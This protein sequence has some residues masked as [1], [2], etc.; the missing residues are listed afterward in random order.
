MDV[1]VLV[2][3]LC[4]DYGP[5][6]AVHDLSFTVEAGEIFALVGP[7][8]AGKSTTL[9][10]LEGYRRPTGGRVSVLGM[11]PMSGGRDLRERIGIVLQEAG[12][13]EEFSVRELVELYIGFYPRRHEVDEL[14]DLV[15]LAEKRGSRV[16]TLSGGQRRRLDLALGLA[17][18]PDLIFLDEPT[19]GFDPSAR[20]RAWDLVNALRGLGKTV[21]LTT[22]YMDEA[23]HLADRVAVINSGRLV[24]LGSPEQLRS[25][26][27]RDTVISCRLPVAVGRADLPS[28]D[29]VARLDDHTL[30]LASG[31][32]TQDLHT[33]TGWAIE[34]GFELDSL[35]LARP[36]LEEIYLR[37]TDGDANGG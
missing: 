35:K 11:E 17:G 3:N 1:A 22:H 7:N 6:R 26:G 16:K 8:G 21:L 15:G 14:I 10:V 32:P 5:L 23:E 33:L 27:E 31:H 19:T 13:D 4:V 28:V 37:L 2:E 24:A 9:E 29:G 34:R 20:R 25:A 36:S 12:F 18:D 30:E